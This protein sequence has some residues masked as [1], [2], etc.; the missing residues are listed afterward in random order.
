MAHIY[1][2]D[3]SIREEVRQVLE[4]TDG[5]GQVLEE[6]WK[7]FYSLEHDRAGDYIAVA[8]DRSWFTYYFWEQ[9]KK[10]PDYARTVDIH[11]KPGYDPV[12]LFLAENAGKMKIGGKLLRKKLGFRTLMN[13]IPLDA[14]L[15]RGSHGRVPENSD[16]WPILIG[17]FKDLPENESIPAVGV[18]ERLVE[19]CAVGYGY[20]TESLL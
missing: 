16:D 18:Y 20:S 15:V 4:D 6:V 8:D 19:H 17:D 13:V 11:R 9:D 5:V 3:E 2:N 1:I 7:H 14:T 12:E 10:A